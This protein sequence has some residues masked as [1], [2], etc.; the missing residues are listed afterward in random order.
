MLKTG[1][2]LKKRAALQVFSEV[3]RAFLL[4]RF[5]T[6]DEVGNVLQGLEVLLFFLLTLESKLVQTCPFSNE[7]SDWQ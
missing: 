2:S 5:R 1:R 7:R 4:Q 6:V 3:V